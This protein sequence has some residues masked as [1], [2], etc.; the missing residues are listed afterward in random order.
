M[1][2]HIRS[3]HPSPL[4][5]LLPLHYAISKP[6]Q[7]DRSGWPHLRPLIVR[8]YLRFKAAAIADSFNNARHEGRAVQHAH[9]LWHTDVRVD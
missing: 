5:H 4:Q 3:F 9:L 7:E 2:F 6:N 8:C 1:F